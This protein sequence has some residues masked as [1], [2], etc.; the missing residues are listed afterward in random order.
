MN[1]FPSYLTRCLVCLSQAINVVLCDGYPDEMLSSR[2]YRCD[3]KTTRFVIDKLFWWQAD[4]CQQ[5]YQWE[6][7]RIDSPRFEENG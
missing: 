5:C 2:A 4:H 1:D 6:R 3:W 7:D